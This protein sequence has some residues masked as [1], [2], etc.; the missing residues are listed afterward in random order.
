LQIEINVTMSVTFE[1][2]SIFHCS[3]DK[4]FQFHEEKV[5]FETLVGLDKSVKVLSAPS[6]ISQ[7]GTQAILNVSILPGV[8]TKWIAE[9]IEYRKNELFVDIQRSGP[10][11]NF[12]HEHRF[13]SI[14]DYSELNDHIEFEFFLNPISKHF[15]AQKLKSQFKARHEATANY[16]QVDYDT[17]YCGLI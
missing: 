17:K 2:R 12:R 11:K 14:G 6:S 9:H 10:F 3:V 4:L 5:G 8:K 16:L 1:C 15:V 13:I 7:I